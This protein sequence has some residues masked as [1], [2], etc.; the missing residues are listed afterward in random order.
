MWQY[1]ML[2]NSKSQKDLFAACNKYAINAELVKAVLLSGTGSLLN[3][4]SMIYSV[5]VGCNAAAK[6]SCKI[7]IYRNSKSCI[8]KTH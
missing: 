4:Q 3:R 2:E 8:F 5:T 6:L 1:R 7:Q